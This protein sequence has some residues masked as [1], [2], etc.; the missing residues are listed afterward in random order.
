MTSYLRLASGEGEAADRPV[1]AG[2]GGNLPATG[3]HNAG[4]GRWARDQADD[5]DAHLNSADVDIY[6]VPLRQVRH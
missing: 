6:F 2:E 3:E 4:L 1:E 5:V